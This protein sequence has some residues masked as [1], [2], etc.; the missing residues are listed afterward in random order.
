VDKALQAVTG[1]RSVKPSQKGDVRKASL[2]KGKGD[3]A[4][5]ERIRKVSA[6]A[7]KHG[8]KSF[9]AAE[10]AMNRSAGA[11]KVGE[12]LKGRRHNTGDGGREAEKAVEKA[13]SK[14]RKMKSDRKVE[15][16]TK[17]RSKARKSGNAKRVRRISRK[18]TNE[19]R[20]D[21]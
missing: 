6:Y 11:K 13:R 1:G 19:Q 18:L 14:A 8:I 9:S 15:R 21:T 4:R 16:L 10:T 20:G 17:K 5:A 2:A 7:N 12:G 3:E